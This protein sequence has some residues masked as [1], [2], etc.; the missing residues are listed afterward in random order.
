MKF[1]KLAKLLVVGLMLTSI[2]AGCKGP[3]RLTPLLGRGTRNPT[4]TDDG[5]KGPIVPPDKGIATDTGPKSIPVNPSGIPTTKTDW[6]T[7]DPN[8]AEFAAQTVYFDFDKAIVKSTEVSK[9][10]VVA[11]RMKSF[12][13]KGLRVE[14]HCDER[15]TEEYNRSLGERRALA[16][17]EVLVKLGLDPEFIDTVSFGEDR[18]AD[19]GHNEAAWKKNRRG[20]LILLTPRG[21]N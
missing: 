13:G 20:E 7:A 10:E 19:P 18:P 16:I 15:G 2:L 21:G 11:N 14:G 5:I 6:T 8:R 4:V 3:Q 17:R 1:L 12:Q 9:L